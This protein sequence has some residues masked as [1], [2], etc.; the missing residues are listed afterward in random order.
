MRGRSVTIVT[1]EPEPPP[2]WACGGLTQAW[3]RR[4][5]RAVFRPPYSEQL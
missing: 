1:G 2:T 5:R 3:P 4:G